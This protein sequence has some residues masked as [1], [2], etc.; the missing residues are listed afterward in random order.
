MGRDSLVGY[1]AP[2]QSDVQNLLRKRGGDWDSEH[3]GIEVEGMK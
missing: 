1:V 2:G 3:E